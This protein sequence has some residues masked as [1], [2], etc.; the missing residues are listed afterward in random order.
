MRKLLLLSLIASVVAAILILV[1]CKKETNPNKNHSPALPEG[2]DTIHPLNY[3]PVFPGSYWKY[4]DTINDT[5]LITT[6]DEYMKDA[7]RVDGAS[8][9]S[10]TF[11]VPMYTYTPF[12]NNT[13]IWG[14]EAHTGPISNAGSYPLTRLV[15]DSL[16]VG[17]SWTIYNWSGTT[18]DRKIIAIDTTISIDGIDYFPT[19]VVEEYYTQGPPSYI[20]INKRYFTKDIGLIKEELL[21][22]SDS[23]IV[24]KL[25]LEFNV[26]YPKRK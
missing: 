14:Y 20:W 16:P 26:N 4:I 8:F 7:Y 11:F 18:I 13:P 19:I 12:Y 10:D 15:S 6:H 5:I 24:T 3:F 23:S 9:Q 22:H 17:S 1:S 2:F 21:N 25:I